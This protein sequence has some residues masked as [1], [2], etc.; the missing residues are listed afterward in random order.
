M[1]LNT[2]TLALCLTLTLATPLLAQSP[3]LASSSTTLPEAPEPS[4]VQGSNAVLPASTTTKYI[5]PNQPA[6]RL[7]TRDKFEL[8]FKHAISPMTMLGWAAASG[9]EQA[10]N[11]SPN[12][13]TNSYAY[14]QRFGAAA[15]RNASEDIFSDAVLASIL[16]EDP[17]YYR[18]G[19]GPGQGPV[20]RVLHAVSR[21]FIS[22]TDSG[23]T[24]PN[25]SLLGGNLAGSYLTRAYYPP[26]NRSNKEILKTFGGSLGG[27]AL[28]FSI[29]EF[30]SGALNIFHGD[31]PANY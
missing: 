14:A 25:F 22:Q 24:M 28:D 9:Y 30:L 16:H 11:G 8:G 26:H 23:R 3:L 6:P 17:R 7:D 31:R 5:A 2:R 27:S 12:Y 10:L 21:T 29:S 1:T 15:A 19:P 13:G 4:N 18:M 20:R